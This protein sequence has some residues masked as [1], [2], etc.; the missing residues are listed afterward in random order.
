MSE[1]KPC[2]FCGAEPMHYKSFTKV[3]IG[4]RSADCHVNPTF[5]IGKRDNPEEKWNSRICDRMVEEIA[6]LRSFVKKVSELDIETFHFENQGGD[7]DCFEYVCT[8][9]V[10]DAVELLAKLNQEGEE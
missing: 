2:P 5:S 7:E 1:L 8:D 3:T 4:C 10:D 6:K 9:I